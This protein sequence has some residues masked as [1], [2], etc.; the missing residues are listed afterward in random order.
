MLLYDDPR[1]MLWQRTDALHAQTPWCTV[2]ML[3]GVSHGQL[4]PTQAPGTS[5][6]AYLARR[7][8]LVLLALQL[9]GRLNLSDQARRLDCCVP[10]GLLWVLT[11]KMPWLVLHSSQRDCKSSLRSVCTSMGWHNYASCL[12]HPVSV[13][14]TRLASVLSPLQQELLREPASTPLSQHI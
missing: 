1:C 4:M 6:G 13:Q 7:E 10:K 12:A 8:A 9:A 14:F 2:S 5:T 11:G 3:L